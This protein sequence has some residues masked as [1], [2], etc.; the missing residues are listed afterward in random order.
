VIHADELRAAA[1]VIRRATELDLTDDNAQ[2]STILN[3]D[4]LA[5]WM[6]GE[7]FSWDAPGFTTVYPAALQF[8][9]SV[10]DVRKPPEANT[11]ATYE[12][13]DVYPAITSQRW[14]HEGWRVLNAF[15]VANLDVIAMWVLPSGVLGFA[16]DPY[17]AGTL[18]GRP[19][20]VEPGATPHLKIEL[21]VGR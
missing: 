5:D 20:V 13:T 10:V 3:R 1:A 19:F 15:E 16:R 12:V 21:T 18:I 9:R 2:T 14:F 8:A 4:A 11:P 7:A 6:Q 17:S